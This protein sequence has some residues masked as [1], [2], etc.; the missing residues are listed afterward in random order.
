[1]ARGLPS[2]TA[3]LGLLAIAGYQNRDKLAAM[4]G[5][6]SASTPAGSGVAPQPHAGGGMGSIFGN[7][8]GAMGAGG[9]G[10][11]LGNGLREL[12][13][14]FHENGKGD[15]AQSWI[16]TG[17]NKPI[18]PHELET[19]LGPDMVAELSQ[20][21]GLSREQLLQRLATELPNAVDKYTPDGQLPP[22]Q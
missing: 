13:E 12:A 15:V 17:P 18:A 5:G 3:L 1:M 4:F 22:P 2:M 21:T 8:G 11:M 16:G 20:K 10:G 7:L 6:A 19:A 9:I 14:R